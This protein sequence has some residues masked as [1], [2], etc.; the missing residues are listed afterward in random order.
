[1]RRSRRGDQ[2]PK[3]HELFFQGFWLEV[4]SRLYS[5]LKKAVKNPLWL[6]MSILGRFMVF[7]SAAHFFSPSAPFLQYDEQTSLFNVNDINS[8]VMSLKKDGIYSGIYLPE[9]IRAEIAEF[10]ENHYTYGDLSPDLGF[11]YAEKEQI[12]RQINRRFYTAQYY[13]TSQACPAIDRIRRDPA[14]LAIAKAYLH[15]EPVFTGS[16]L[17]WIFSVDT[18]SY[19]TSKT[20]CFFHYDLDDYCCLRFFFYLTYVD[21]SSGP[22]VCI[23]GSH[24]KKKLSYVLSPVKRRSDQGLINYYGSERILTLCGDSGFGFAEDTFIYHKATRPQNRDRLM[25]Q[26]Q[27]ATHDY[28]NH[29]DRIDPARLKNA[30][31]PS[32]RNG[33]IFGARCQKQ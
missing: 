23:Q 25:L 26:I 8:V 5:Y 12:E 1:V 7:R 17:W 14:L 32:G 19:D 27:F 28:G 4:R 6:I 9:N 16:R 13:N 21:L 22:H 30:C 20:V 2:G 11:I 24:K 15:T 33:E 3:T 18:E 29:H 31:R 10:A